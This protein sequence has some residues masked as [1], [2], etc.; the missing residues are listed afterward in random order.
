MNIEYLIR[1]L[2][3]NDYCQY[4]ELIN[5]FRPSIFNENEFKENLNKINLSSD[6]WII[7]KDNKL[8]ATGTII[9]ENKFIFNIC[10]CCHIE[11][12][13]VKKGLRNFGYGKIM[14]NYLI[15]EAKKNNCYKIN[16]VCNKDTSKF[17]KSCNFEER[18]VQMSYLIE[19]K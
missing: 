19:K 2:S 18:G 8:I 11:D 15:D 7:E 9:Y 16:L 3:N 12:I 17:Y 14:M 13:C 5:D 6:I 4:L 10:K 1:K